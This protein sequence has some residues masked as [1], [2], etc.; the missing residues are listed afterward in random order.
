MQSVF[1]LTLRQLSGRWRMVIMALL[2]LAPIAFSALMVSW[3]FAPDMIEFETVVLVTMLA[4]SIGPLIVVSIASV[5]FANEIEDRTLANL[6]LTPIPRWKI[7]LPK[8]VA[9]MVVAA[10]FTV[11]SSALVAHIAFNHDLTATVAVTVSAFA[12]LALYSS[13]FIWLGL[14]T[15]QAIG[16]GLLYIVLWEGFFGTFVSGVRLLSIRKYAA[17]IMHGM[18][19]RRLSLDEHMP[20]LAALAVTV[21]G[22]SGFFAMSVKRLRT[23][24]VP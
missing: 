20:L 22:I 2:A 4:A 12:A 5:S 18:D 23:M 11:G 8:L 21:I 17:A 3:D 7:V 9:S 6:T 16:V 13:A 14:V 15:K 1:F 10:P 24:D 19:P